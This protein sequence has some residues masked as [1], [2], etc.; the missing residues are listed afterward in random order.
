MPQE[1]GLFITIYQTTYA[2]FLRLL[3]EVPCE[4]AGHTPH[5]QSLVYHL[6]RWTWDRGLLP[7]MTEDE[8]GLIATLSAYHDAGKTMLQPT[9]IY[10]PGPLSPTEL[11]QLKTHP[12]WGEFLVDLV[13]PELRGTTTHRYACEICRW[14][15][16]RWDGGGYPDGLK[17]KE[18]PRYVQVIGLADAY[19]ALVAPRCYKAPIRHRRAANMILGGECG[20][21]WPP[22]LTVFAERASSIQPEV[23]DE[24]P[25]PPEW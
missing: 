19:D 6:L 14:H 15:H 25:D 3:A 18:I 12:A 9:I 24:P 20:A 4:Y 11:E 10:K 13:I 7:D 21:F 17:G 8:L 16:E 22:L 1:G 5:F 23:Y 2:P